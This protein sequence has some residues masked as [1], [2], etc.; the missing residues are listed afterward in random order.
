M[1]TVLGGGIWG[2]MGASGGS[3]RGKGS[4]ISMISTF[5]C[6]FTAVAGVWFLGG[7]TRRWAISPAKFEIFLIFTYFLGF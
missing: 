5:A 1:A 3:G 4:L 7:G 2:G 6:F